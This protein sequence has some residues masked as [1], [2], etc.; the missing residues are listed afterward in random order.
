V[1]SAA[2][3][4]AVPVHQS[5]SILVQMRRIAEDNPHGV[6]RASSASPTRAAMPKGGEPNRPRAAMRARTPS[7]I[8]KRVDRPYSS[9][10]TV[11]MPWTCPTARA[12]LRG[13]HTPSAFAGV[14]PGSRTR[15]GHGTNTGKIS[16]SLRRS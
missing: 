14:A 7:G 6:R 5:L 11:A 3:V 15:V 2:R 8:T 10:W 1:P 16:G 12:S 13:R 4:R 9:L